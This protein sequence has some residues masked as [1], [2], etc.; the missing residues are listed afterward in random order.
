[1][2]DKPQVTVV[3]GPPGSGKSTYVKERAKPGDLI[4]DLDDIWQALSGQPYYDKPEGLL[5]FVWAARD[6]MM[7]RLQEPSAIYRAWIVSMGVTASV[8]QGYVDDY[9]ATIIM[10]DV[11]KGECLNRIAKDSRRADRAEA[12][13]EIV[14]RWFK[15]YQPRDG[16][17]MVKF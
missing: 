16:D 6:G 2:T 3:C 7:L 1:M 11:H 8:R 14:D 10:L 15:N 17:I 5:T 9:N 4:V 13:T 12:W